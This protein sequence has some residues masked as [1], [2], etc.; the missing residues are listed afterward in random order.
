MSPR[1]H[2]ASADAWERVRHGVIDRRQLLEV[3]FSPRSIKHRVAKRWLH[4]LWRGVYAVARP[5]ITRH[6]WWLAA[7]YACGEGALLSHFSAAA[8]YGILA[9]PA[10][11]IHVSVPLNARR[12]R[13]GIAIHAR[14]LTAADRAERDA[15]PVTSIATTI[16]DLATSL[17]RGPLEGV[18]NQADILG[19]ITVPALRAEIDAMPKRAGRKPL[20]DTIDRRTFRFTRSELERRFIPL[21]LGAG[22]SR[23]ETCAE[24]NGWEVDFYW[25]DLDLVVETDGLTYHRTPAQQDRDRRR[26]QAHAAAGTTQLRFTHS[27]VRYEP[28]YVRAMLVAVGRRLA[29]EQVGRELEQV[30]H[31]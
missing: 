21:A 25:P 4:P 7:V 26:D 8:L 12:T 29:R 31:G 19:L 9:E 30:G 11:P 24:V 6:G 5:E 27:Q 14:A 10:G 23:P 3:G 16:A 1:L 22:L 18:I 2:P 28:G 13:R 15:I 20:R 17:R